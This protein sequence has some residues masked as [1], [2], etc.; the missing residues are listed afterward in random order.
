MFAALYSLLLQHIVQYSKGSFMLR[1]EIIW[2][3][4]I[5]KSYEDKIRRGGGYMLGGDLVLTGPNPFLKK[6]SNCHVADVT[7]LSQ[8][9]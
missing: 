7:W 4:E 1:D 8:V 2:S 9:D 5:M 3:H 6:W